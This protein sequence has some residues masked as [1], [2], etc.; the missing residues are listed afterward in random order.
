MEIKIRCPH[1]KSDRLNKAG[2][3]YSGS[4]RQSYY[5]RDCHKITVK[6]EIVE[7]EKAEA[8]LVEGIAPA[9]VEITDALQ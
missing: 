6:P 5:C 8:I 4:L 7:K 2:M 1:C 3:R 9:D